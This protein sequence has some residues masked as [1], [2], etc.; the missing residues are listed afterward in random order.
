MQ[1]APAHSDGYA[2]IY[3][4]RLNGSRFIINGEMIR[5]IEATPDTVITL[6][7]GEKVIV[8]EAVDDIVAAVVEYRRRIQAGVVPDGNA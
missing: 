1:C 5:E 7:T 8:R 6:V 3:V 2:M 4:T